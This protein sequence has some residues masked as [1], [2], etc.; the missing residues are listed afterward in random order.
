VTLL[1]QIHVLDGNQAMAEH[2]DSG[3]ISLLPA[4]SNALRMDSLP[5]LKS[6]S[7]FSFHLFSSEPA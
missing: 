4:A 5:L 3:A 7:S 6:R 1:L 2:V